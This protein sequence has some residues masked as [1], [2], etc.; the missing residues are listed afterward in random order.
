V[1]RPTALIE[2]STKL[3]PSMGRTAANPLARLKPRA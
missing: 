1:A 3:Q 2:W